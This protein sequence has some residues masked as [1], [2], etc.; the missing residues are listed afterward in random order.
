MGWKYEVEGDRAYAIRRAAEQ[1]AECQTDVSIANG[2]AYGEGFGLV[3]DGGP[4]EHLPDV[5]AL[6]AALEKL[7]SR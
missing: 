5:P 2:S 6:F 3:R 7:L 1:I 4:V